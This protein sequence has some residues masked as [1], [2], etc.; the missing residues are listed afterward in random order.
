[1]YASCRFIPFYF[2]IV[3]S[4]LSTHV[5]Q[6]QYLGGVVRDRETGQP[7]RAASITVGNLRTA[8]EASGRFGLAGFTSFPVTI[9]ISH[10]GYEPATLTMSTA[11]DPLLSILLQSIR[12][13]Q[14]DGKTCG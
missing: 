1:M 13:E 9:S 14:R 7:V 4:I 3:C 6:A 5:V 11:P 10:I 8:T 2:L 12:E